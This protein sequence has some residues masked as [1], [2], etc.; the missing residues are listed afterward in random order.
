MFRARDGRVI[1]LPPDMTVAEATTLETEAL[2]AEKK[3]GKGPLPKPVPDVKK[4]AAKEVKK[5]KGKGIG[6]LI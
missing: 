2:A 6:C 4:L 1:E 5:E 3:L